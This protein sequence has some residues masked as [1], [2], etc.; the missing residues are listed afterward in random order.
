M[1]V[2]LC[3]IENEL[4]LTAVQHLKS[5][6]FNVDVLVFDGLMVRIEE[7]KEIDD[8]L[9]SS[10]SQYVKDKSGNEMKFVEKSMEQTIDLSIYGNLES[11]FRK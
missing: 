11:R 10:L 5:I 8:N 1:N 3:K 2:I 4:L 6:E 7:G 9:L